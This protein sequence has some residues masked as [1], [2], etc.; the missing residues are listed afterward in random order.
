MGSFQYEREQAF[1][2][3]L[4]PLPERA[5]MVLT[6]AI[7][8][9]TTTLSGTNENLPSSIFMSDPEILSEYDRKKRF[10]ASENTLDAFYMAGHYTKQCTTLKEAVR[11]V[12]APQKKLDFYNEYMERIPHQFR[13][14]VLND[15]LHS[16]HTLWAMTYI[17]RTDEHVCKDLRALLDEIFKG[18]EGGCGLDPPVTTGSGDMEEQAFSENPL[19]KTHWSVMCPSSFIAANWTYEVCCGHALPG[20]NDDV[21]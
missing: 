6:R 15:N 4:G 1:Q 21:F 16:T 18:E 9:T 2:G 5:D 11:S 13:S 19:S 12:H 17:T 14:L 7:Y 8:K 3:S 20:S 10:T